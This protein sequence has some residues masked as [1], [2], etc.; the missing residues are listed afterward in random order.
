MTIIMKKYVITGLVLMSMFVTKPLRSLSTE[1]IVPEKPIELEVS[2]TLNT[3]T[4]YNPT[5]RQCDSSPLIT[6]SNKRIDKDKLYKQEIKWMAVSRNLLKKWNG[7]FSYGDTVLLTSGDKS[8][9]GLWVIHDNMNKRFK[10]RGD[11]LFDSRIRSL[12]KWKDVKISKR[13]PAFKPAV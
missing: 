4:I 2:A 1:G 10:D 3:L 12:G 8:I 6:A 9:D 11:L 5:H 7:E 13:V